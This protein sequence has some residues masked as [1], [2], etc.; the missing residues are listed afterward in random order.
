[1]LGQNYCDYGDSVVRQLCHAAAFAAL[2]SDR[3]A[4]T[5]DIIR[6]PNWTTVPPRGYQKFHTANIATAPPGCSIRYLPTEFTDDEK[7]K[8]KTELQIAALN[9]ENVANELR[10]AHTDLRE[11]L[12]LSNSS[13]ATPTSV[14]TYS[15]TTSVPTD[16]PTHAPTQLVHQHMGSE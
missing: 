11:D 5:D 8:S 1:M 12:V 9:V 13:N 15:P 2:P 10:E 3:T 6:Y 7:K 16:S 14:P 4:S